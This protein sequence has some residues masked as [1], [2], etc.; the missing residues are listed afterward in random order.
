MAHLTPIE[1]QMARP[2]VLAISKGTQMT[3]LETSKEVIMSWFE[4]DDN[5]YK[6]AQIVAYISDQ[7]IP[8][9]DRKEVW[10]N[11]PEHLATHDSWVLHLPKFENKY[12]R[13][14]WYDDFYYERHSVVNLVDCLNRGDIFDDEDGEYNEDKAND[15]I[16][17]CMEQGVHSFTFDW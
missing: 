2:H 7:T 12:G 3:T 10:M 5:D 16:A 4:C 9:E 6:R 15:F 17:E 1:A 11:T 8:F 14:S 13:I